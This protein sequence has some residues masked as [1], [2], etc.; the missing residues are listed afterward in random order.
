MPE[1]QP[2]NAQHHYSILLSVDMPRTML[3]EWQT[4]VDSYQ[5]PH[6][7]RL[8]FT[9]RLANS[10]HDKLMI[11]FLG[12]NSCFIGDPFP[13]GHWEQILFS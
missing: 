9:A 7:G 12:A 4:Y 8:T 2:W 3:V 5:M 6:S 1:I 13:E 11:F 10:A